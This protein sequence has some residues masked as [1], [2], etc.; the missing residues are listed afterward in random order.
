MRLAPLERDVRMK[1]KR[2]M[3]SPYAR[4]SV[5][6]KGAGLGRS[7]REGVHTHLNTTNK[8]RT[9][10]DAIKY[11]LLAEY[12][13]Q[14]DVDAELIRNS[15]AFRRNP[16][17]GH[18]VFFTACNVN[19]LQGHIGRYELFQQEY[20]AYQPTPLT[21]EWCDPPLADDQLVLTLGFNPFTTV[22]NVEQAQHTDTEHSESDADPE[23][24]YI[25]Y[26]EEQESYSDADEHNKYYHSNADY[27][28]FVQRRSLVEIV[29]QGESMDDCAYW[30]WSPRYTICLL[31][32]LTP[33]PD[34]SYW[35]DEIDAGA[36]NYVKGIATAQN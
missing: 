20:N 8:G 17:R 10:Y 28:L 32:H 24:Y 7:Q 22:F 21:Q 16:T 6:L 14:H 33:E 29:Y 12:D 26:Y 13:R 34:A 25:S 9:D 36:E 19:E 31:A 27:S 3:A 5:L 18:K 1:D 15:M 23:S 4:S 2:N 30:E 35:Q 11:D